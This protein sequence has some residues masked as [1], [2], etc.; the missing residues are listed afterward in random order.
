MTHAFRNVVGAAVSAAALFTIVTMAGSASAAITGCCFGPT[1]SNQDTFACKASGGTALDST[2]KNAND[3]RCGSC[4]SIPEAGPRGLCNAYCDRL[5]CPA[6]HPGMACE[7]LRKNWMRATNL[8]AFPCDVPDRPVCCQCPGAGPACSSAKRCLKA[9]CQIIDRCINGECPRPQC[10][11]CANQ[12]PPSCGDRIPGLCKLKGCTPKADA[13]CTE[14]GRCEQCPCG[15][16]CKD[17]DGNVGRCVN[18]PGSPECACQ[19]PAPCGFNAAGQCGGECTDSNDKCTVVT[20]PAG[21]VKCECVPSD[22]CLNRVPC[23]ETCV[24]LSGNVGICRDTDGGCRCLPPSTECPPTSAEC[25]GPCVTA[26][27]V[28]GKCTPGDGVACACMTPPQPCEA[29]DPDTCNGLCTAPGTL[30]L[31]DPNGGPCRCQPP[32]KCEDSAPQ[33]GGPCPEGLSCQHA[34]GSNGCVCLPPVPCETSTPP[35]CGGVCPE[36]R[37]CISPTNGGPCACLPPVC[38]ASA[39]QC[40]GRCPQGSFCTFGLNDNECLCR[41]DALCDATCSATN[42][43]V[44]GQPGFCTIN[45]STAACECKTSTS[46]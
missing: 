41:Q 25:A 2:C 34:A 17:A 19:V 40:G 30:C 32:P 4:A 5:N 21:I 11:E 6:G 35:Q 22:P 27:G 43:T 16:E 23:D 10:C 29:S 12:D 20:D 33:C 36:G 14:R 8:T 3:A 9:Q 28:P 44:N 37:L 24:D 42:C 31:P 1:C 39:P 15:T 46:P 45:T 7:Q 38:E 18:V 26:N 13:M